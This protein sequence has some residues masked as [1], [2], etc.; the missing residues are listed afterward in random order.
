MPNQ[1][2]SNNTFTAEEGRFVVCSELYAV[3]A[4]YCEE[5]DRGAVSD[6]YP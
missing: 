2:I 1:S 3:E 4:E 5:T 6:V